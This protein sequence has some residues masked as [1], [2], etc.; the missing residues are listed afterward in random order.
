VR[1]SIN[2]SA[3]NTAVGGT[4]LGNNTTGHD[5]TAVG[6]SALPNNTSGSNNV[7]LGAFA[8]QAVTTSSNVICI[9]VQGSDTDNS[10][11]IGSI[12]GQTTNLGSAV[13]IDANNKLGTMTS[14]KRYKEDIKPMD[15]LSKA[16]FALK[17][18]SF[19]YKKQ[20]DPAGTSQFGLVAEDVEKVSPDLVVRD[21]DGK[22]YSVRYD[23]VNAML[24]NEFIKEHKKV[25]EQQGTIADL[26]SEMKTLAAIVQEQALQLRD[27]KT[28]MQTKSSASVIAGNY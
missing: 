14:S 7:T 28:Q 15:E 9:G 17:P 22:P 23:Q 11:F 2:T 5:N 8:G 16:L 4:A 21:K 27:V 20:F 25:E 24:L 19:R 13:F 18:V 12:F 6:I 26:K 3:D 1:L 10:C